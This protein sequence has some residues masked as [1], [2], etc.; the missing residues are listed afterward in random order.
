MNDLRRF[1]K[2]LKPHWAAFSIATVAMVC[3]GLLESALRAL[4]VPILDLASGVKDGQPSATLFGL[5]RYVP[6]EGGVAAWRT[7]AIMMV[8]FTATKGIAEYFSTYLM[9]RIG[10]SSVLKLREELYRHV[11]SQ[12]AAFFERNRSN[13]IVSR[14]VTSAAAIEDAV[15]GTVRDMLRESFTLIAYLAA[16]NCATH[17]VL[18]GGGAGH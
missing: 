11:L 8:A 17:R 15:S 7:I 14:I 3:V 10:Q 6:F 4:V 13:Y 9:A 2:Y 1:L 12:S 18:D 5:Q 16:S